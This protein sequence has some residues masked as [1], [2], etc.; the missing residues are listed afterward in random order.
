[1]PRDTRP[2]IERDHDRATLSM[3]GVE[4]VY[5]LSRAYLGELIRRG[6]IPGVRRGRAIR[7]LRVDVEAW[8]RREAAR[9]TARAEAVA[10]R[11][12]ERE[13]RSAG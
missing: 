12:L 4:R 10:E 9:T 2:I 11:V 1:M 13:A 8:W 3:R 7:V 5:G 6:E